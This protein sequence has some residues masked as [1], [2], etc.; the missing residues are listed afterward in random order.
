MSSLKAV[1][2]NIAKPTKDAEDAANRLGIEFDIAA[3]Q[4]KG[5]GPRRSHPG[6]RTGPALFGSVEAFNAVF[7]LPSRGLRSSPTPLLRWR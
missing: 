2:A 5:C 4:S 1:I 6:G 3:L 7:W